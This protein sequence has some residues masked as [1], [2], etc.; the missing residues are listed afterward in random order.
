MVSKGSICPN[1]VRVGLVRNPN[2][3][4]SALMRQS[5]PIEREFGMDFQDMVGDT[6]YCIHRTMEPKEVT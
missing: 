6:M 5:I 1:S 4:R 2:W 3:F